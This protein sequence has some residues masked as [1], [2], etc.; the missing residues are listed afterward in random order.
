MGTAVGDRRPFTAH[1]YLRRVSDGQSG[2]GSCAIGSQA[3]AGRAHVC[4]DGVG[5]WR[6]W[7]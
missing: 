4:H 7:S 6:W 5:E 3:I 2:I 1:G